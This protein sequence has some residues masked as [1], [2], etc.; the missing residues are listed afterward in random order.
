MQLLYKQISSNAY[1]PIKGSDLAAGFD[2]H[3]PI[4][5]K[6]PGKGIRSIY[7]DIEVN[8]PS[9]C[10]GRIAA[11]SGMCLKSYVTVLE[12]NIE[13]NCKNVK[14]TLYNF[15]DRD[16]EVQKGDRIAQLICEKNFNYNDIK[17]DSIFFKKLSID[18]IKPIPSS[19]SIFHVFSPIEVNIPSKSVI[20]IPIYIQMIL[21]NNNYYG[22]VT[23]IPEMSINNHVIVLENVITNAE[24]ESKPKNIYEKI[25]INVSLYNFSNVDYKVNKYDKIAQI[26]CEKIINPTLTELSINDEKKI[27]NNKLFF[28]KLSDIALAPTQTQ[29]GFNLYSPRTETIP[30]DGVI[31]IKTNLQIILPDDDCYGRIASTREN[32]KN[33]T[34]LLGGVIDKDYEGDI[35]VILYNFGK[36]D[37][38][39]HKG[40]IIARIIC[41]NIHYPHLMKLISIHPKNNIISNNSINRSIKKIRGNL[42][43]GSS[44]GYTVVS[45]K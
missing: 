42:G 27:L 7:T 41:E 1:S 34:I 16:Y 3:S 43:F 44:G 29:P 37:R 13:R 32:I 39:I 18:A 9:G 8:L 17:K 31:C 4:Y 38:T 2:L 35:G 6:I 23:S 5:A 22:R 33:L 14:I 25:G 30:S 45:N 36:K 19:S 21:P 24:K 28:K 15:G 10:Y 26:I 40:D 12:S 11:R 20:S